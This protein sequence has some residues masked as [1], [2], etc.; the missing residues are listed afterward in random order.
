[1]D[2]YISIMMDGWFSGSE[3]HSTP[4][5]STPEGPANGITPTN[6]FL[7]HYQ[8][9]LIRQNYITGHRE[10]Q[11]F[12]NALFFGFLLVDPSSVVG[13][14]ASLALSTGPS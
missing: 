3:P 1:M 13:T 4:P 8:V 11:H 5:A 6:T 14:A 2:K 10:L 7:L 12:H 9:G